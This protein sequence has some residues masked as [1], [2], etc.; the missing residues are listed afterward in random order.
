MAK[1]LFFKKETKQAGPEI[2]AAVSFPMVLR[3]TGRRW[4]FHQRPREI[5]GTD[6]FVRQTL[7]LA[8]AAWVSPKA[9]AVG[10][11]LFIID[12]RGRGEVT[13]IR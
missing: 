10:N 8:A 6:T 4:R 3:R 5:Y 9:R 1:S 2:P 7:S 12:Y 13:L 11:S